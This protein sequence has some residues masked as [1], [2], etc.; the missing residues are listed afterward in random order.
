MKL[1]TTDM[2]NMT[3][4]S[5]ESISELV[6]TYDTLASSGKIYLIQSLISRLLV[7]EIFTSYF[8]GLPSSRSVELSNLESY[9]TTHTAD[10]AAVNQWRS[11][12]LA[13]LRKGSPEQLQASTEALITGLVAKINT[14]LSALTDIQPSQ[15]RDTT[16]RALINSAIDL[17]RLLRVQKAIFKPIM[18][19]IEAHQINVFDSETMEDIGGED[20]DGLEGREIRCVAFPGMVKEG[21]ESGEGIRYRNVI[22]KARVLCLPEE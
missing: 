20:E 9:L 7:L 6:P 4:A 18:P 19:V 13:V 5:K 21:E 11:T 8:V 1:T 16:L 14:F 12:T 17:S 2:S 10:P 22:A 15:Q 3:G